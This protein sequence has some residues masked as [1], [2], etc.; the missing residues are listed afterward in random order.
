MSDTVV[1]SKEGPSKDVES[2]LQQLEGAVVQLRDSSAALVEKLEPVLSSPPQE[3]EPPA[4]APTPLT[5]LGQRLQETIHTME[6]IQVRITSA[7]NR[8]EI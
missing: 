4:D 5:A 6:L 3:K 8:L 2:K 7:Y 1:Q